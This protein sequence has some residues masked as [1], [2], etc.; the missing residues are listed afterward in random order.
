MNRE[1]LKTILLDEDFK[2]VTVNAILRG[3]RRPRYEKVIELERKYGI[4]FD[5]WLDITAYLNDHSRTTTTRTSRAH[6]AENQR[7]ETA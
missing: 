3:A 2:P 4:P 5:A 6:E 1:K 7:K